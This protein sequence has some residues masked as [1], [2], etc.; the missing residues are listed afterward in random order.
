MVEQK[1]PSAESYARPFGLQGLFKASAR[2]RMPTCATSNLP[3]SHAGKD[4]AKQT[5]QAHSQAGS[6][7]RQCLGW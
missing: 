2:T 5:C 3:N 6:Q 7:A 4:I 1:I